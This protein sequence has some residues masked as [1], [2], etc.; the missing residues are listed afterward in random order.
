[1]APYSEKKDKTVGSFTG[2]PAS[3]IEYRRMH[4]RT[5]S[6]P[7]NYEGDG[8]QEISIHV[9]ELGAMG[10]HKNNVDFSG[11][12]EDLGRGRGDP[13]IDRVMNDLSSSSAIGFQQLIAKSNVEVV[14]PRVFP[15]PLHHLTAFASPSHHQQPQQHHQHNNKQ[16]QN[17]NNTST[18]LKINLSK[19]AHRRSFT[20]ND[21]Y[22]FM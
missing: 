20:S 19:L 3:E 21:D 9:E 12:V 6:L 14:L 10:D 4:E 22:C 2:S 18:H 5:A 1:M 8:K 17:Q 16:S 11:R 13:T 15:L 7:R